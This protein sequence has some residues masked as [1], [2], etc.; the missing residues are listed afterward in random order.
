MA[1][2]ESND[3]RGYRI[4]LVA[5]ELPITPSDTASNSSRVKVSIYLTNKL[6]TF[7]QYTLSMDVTIHDVK[8]SW[9][10]KPSMLSYNSEILL[11][12]RIVTVKH[13]SDGT[14]KAGIYVNFRG[15]GGWSPGNLIIN[16]ASY[17]LTTLARTSDVKANDANFGETV[18]ITITR[19]SDT[20]THKISY[21]IDGT[22]GV[23]ADNV[24][25][26][27]DWQVPLSLMSTIPDSKTTKCDIIVETNVNGVKTGETTT[28][29]TLTVPESIVPT[30]N[31]ITLYDDNSIAASIYTSNR[32][33]LQLQSKI[34]VVFNNYSGQ[35]GSTIKSFYAEV[36][37]KNITIDKNNGVFPEL[38]FSGSAVIRA[39]VIDS[40]GRSSSFVSKLINIVSYVP[41]GIRFEA[42][43]SGSNQHTVTVKRYASVSP[44]MVNGTQKN[45]MKI[46]F[47]YTE[48]DNQYYINDNGQASGQWY[49][50]ST[51]DGSSANLASNFYPDKSYLIK[52]TIS[53]KFTSTPIEFV[54]SIGGE[55]VVMSI[56]E[57]GIGVQKIWSRGAADI[58]GDVYVSGKVIA[59]GGF[60]GN[61][62]AKTLTLQEVFNAIYPIGSLYMSNNSTNPGSLFTGTW[63]PYAQG[64]TLVGVDYNDYEFNS[65]GRTGGERMHTITEPEMPSHSHQFN[66]EAAGSP[67]AL[68]WENGKGVMRAKTANYTLGI[69]TTYKG[70]GQ[71]HNNMQPYITTYI[72]VRIR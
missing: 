36:E 16:W 19:K 49:N 41:P 11:D 70:G 72:W 27:Y 50:I 62:N 65:S 46:Q 2:F 45:F 51:L 9:S 13:D 26:S 24:D 1:T 20:A 8:Y 57:K 28:S 5:E 42:T 56:A 64:R 30:L 12:S 58:E 34:R 33:F 18:S 69:D 17:T 44:L 66:S 25:T 53:D 21:D 22:K 38:T 29:V 59:S 39:K 52:A 48:T 7:T 43:R 10:N 35:Y 47:S 14:R 31:D 6:V 68:G 67:I 61:T 55:A 63:Q 4:K 23:I 54:T 15:S 32:E 71:P 37:N 60:E 40:R 3:D